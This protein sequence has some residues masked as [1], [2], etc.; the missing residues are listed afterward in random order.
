MDSGSPAPTPRSSH[1]HLRGL[2]NYRGRAHDGDVSFSLRIFCFSRCKTTSSSLTQRTEK[3]ADLPPKKPG[4]PQSP[5]LPPFFLFVPCWKFPKTRSAHR[6]GR[7]GEPLRKP[8]K[9]P[10]PVN[11]LPAGD[12]P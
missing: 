11:P 7:M 5:K 6:R 4:R 1:P 10:R 12:E 8:G 2:A 3:L 9:A